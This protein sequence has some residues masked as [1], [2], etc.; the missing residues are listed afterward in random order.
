MFHYFRFFYLFWWILCS[1]PALSLCMFSQCRNITRI[2]IANAGISNGHSMTNCQSGRIKI[3]EI[4]AI[5]KKTAATID[6]K[7]TY[8]QSISTANQIKIAIIAQMV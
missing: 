2:G 5:G 4:R 3:I 7:E 1:V 8:F 6:A